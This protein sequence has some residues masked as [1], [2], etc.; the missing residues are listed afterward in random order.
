M[1]LALAPWNVTVSSRETVKILVSVLS[2]YNTNLSSVRTTFASAQKSMNELTSCP[3][4]VN[5]AGRNA[6]H[7]SQSSTQQHEPPVQRPRT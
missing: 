6:E 5:N 2:F 7:R 4:A 3:R 1:F